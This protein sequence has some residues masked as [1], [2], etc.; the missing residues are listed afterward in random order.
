MA[1]IADNGQKISYYCG[2]LIR[3][4]KQDIL[5]F[6]DDKIVCVWCIDFMGVT[7]YTNYDFIVSDAPLEESENRHGEY[8]KEMSM[9][10]LLLYLEKQNEK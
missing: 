6:G 1:F 3:E 9:S 10:A 4:L 5:E 7:F 2:D 8:I